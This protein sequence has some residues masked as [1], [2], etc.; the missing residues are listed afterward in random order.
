[1][2]KLH[3]CLHVPWPIYGRNK[4]LKHMNYVLRIK[5]YSHKSKN[6]GSH[7]HCLLPSWTTIQNIYAFLDAIRTCGCISYINKSS[8]VLVY[9]HAHSF[10]FRCTAFSTYVHV[11]NAESAFWR[12]GFLSIYML[13]IFQH[14]N[15]FY[16]AIHP[17]ALQEFKHFRSYRKFFWSVEQILLWG[18][19][20]ALHPINTFPCEKLPHVTKQTWK[21]YASI[22]GHI[23]VVLSIN[24]FKNSLADW[25]CTENVSE[26]SSEKLLCIKSTLLNRV[27]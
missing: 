26:N 8:D 5:M 24:S 12:Y 20:F 15:R 1:M 4:P 2:V 3:K 27:Y 10:Y 14:K 22:C 17:I 16:W 7:W 23:N 18:M 19:I 21:H 13:V 6:I 25:S 9:M 11:G